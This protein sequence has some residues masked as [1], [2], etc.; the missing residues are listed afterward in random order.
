MGLIDLFP[1]S[2]KSTVT[3]HPA[4]GVGLHGAERTF[5]ADRDATAIVLG[6]AG[7]AQTGV[8]IEQNVTHVA[9][10]D[11]HEDEVSL[12]T[13]SEATIESTRRRIKLVEPYPDLG[14]GH[15]T[16]VQLGGR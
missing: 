11:Q 2:S 4:D 6:A 15:V 8:L 10:L 9:Y 16:M 5:G 14:A 1:A 3:L 12:P 7:V 13:G